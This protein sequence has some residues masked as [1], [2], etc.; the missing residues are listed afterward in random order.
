MRSQL[1]EVC[2]RGPGEGPWRRVRSIL[3]GTILMLAA[4]PVVLGQSAA[5]KREQPPAAQ[6]EKAEP[7]PAHKKLVTDLSGFE[8]LKPVN[9]SNS[10]TVVG[11]TRGGAAPDAMAPRLGK[12]CGAG[13]LFAWSNPTGASDFSMVITDDQ[14]SEIYRTH[15]RG[16]SFVYPLA[17]PQLQP[18]K[19]YSWTV[20]AAGVLGGEASDP[21][22]F[23]VVSLK[24]REEIE[25]E[26]AAI[27]K[28]DEWKSGMKRAQVLTDHRLWYDVLGQYSAMIEK[29]P[30]RA[31]LY[32]RR[33][34]IY[35]QLEITKP[36]A[37]MNF[38]ERKKLSASHNSEPH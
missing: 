4:S 17:A 27:P 22:E 15:V 38:A 32:E 1:N 14:D 19:I 12:F 28:G 5:E 18:G 6:A 36:L 23:T 25:R 11:G 31:E 10:Q 13:A 21:V 2:P 29:W 24:E 34:A 20:A 30:G 3:V 7:K 26:L 37:E 8:L 9:G 16:T 33:G 35:E